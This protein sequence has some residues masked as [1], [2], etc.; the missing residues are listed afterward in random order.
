MNQYANRPWY[1]RF[2]FRLKNHF[3][4]PFVNCYTLLY[5]LLLETKKDKEVWATSE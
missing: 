5:Y 4:K 1:M 2:F 3:S